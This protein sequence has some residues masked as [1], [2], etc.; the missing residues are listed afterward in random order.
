MLVPGHKNHE[1]E[2][3]KKNKGDDVGNGSDDGSDDEEF[4]L[5]KAW[6]N[7][8]KD[9]VLPDYDPEEGNLWVAMAVHYISFT[10]KVLS[11]CLPPAEW[12]S[13]YPCLL[14][15]LLMLAA[16]MVVVKEVA[17]QFGCACG[18]SDLMTG[19][20]IVALG[21]SLPDTFA[22]QYA[23]IQ[24]DSAVS[25]RGRLIHLLFSLLLSRASVACACSL[26]SYLIPTSP[27]SSNPQDAAIGCVMGSNAVNVLVGLGLPWI[28]Y[29]GYSA[30]V[31]K[32]EYAVTAGALGFSVIIFFILAVIA[33]VMI[34]VRRKMGG[35]LGART[36]AV[37]VGQD[38]PTAHASPPNVWAINT[39]SPPR[40][41][42]TSSPCLCRC[43]SSSSSSLASTT[44]AGS[45]VSCGYFS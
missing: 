10:F 16:T 38:A 14:A 9:A 17:Q 28:I 33:I 25:D 23:A 35:E 8:F 7:Q 32:S 43:G 34:M 13:G 20:S 44:T 12:M 27:I 3:G 45:P 36:A 29:T 37:Q 15:S 41:S 42:G 11:A 2:K 4:D 18:L 26:D 30:T 31:Q 21:T 39:L 24:D 19:M 6:V 40:C 1:P 5:S 22:A